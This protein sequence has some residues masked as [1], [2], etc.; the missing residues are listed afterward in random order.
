MSGLEAKNIGNLRDMAWTAAATAV[1]ASGSAM[2]KNGPGGENSRR[3]HHYRSS[4][5]TV[6][7]FSQSRK[8]LI[9][10]IISRDN[11]T[12]IIIIILS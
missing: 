2:T 3:G 6:P 4:R 8:F 7:I 1:A 9:I 5:G 11:I 12:V 10:I